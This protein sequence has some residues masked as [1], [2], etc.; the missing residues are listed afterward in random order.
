MLGTLQRAVQ[1]LVADGCDHSVNIRERAGCR[2]LC[3]EPGPGSESR[4]K[5][6]SASRPLILPKGGDSGHVASPQDWSFY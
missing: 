3:A 4:S 5:S 6:H 1:I 2:A